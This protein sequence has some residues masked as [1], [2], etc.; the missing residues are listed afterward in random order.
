MKFAA[1][2]GECSSAALPLPLHPTPPHIALRVLLAD[3]PPP[4]E[5]K[6]DFVLR[7]RCSAFFTLPWKGRVARLDDAQHRWASGVG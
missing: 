5:G 7:T 4:G 6:K 1:G 2:W 3:P